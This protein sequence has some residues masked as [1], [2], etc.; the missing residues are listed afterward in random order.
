MAC[1]PAVLIEQ[2]KCI[3]ACIP[4]GMMPAVNASLLCQI[5]DMSSLPSGLIHYWSLNEAAGS[6]RVD[7]IGGVNLSENGGTID[8]VLG[9]NANAVQFT[10]NNSL[11]SAAQIEWNSDFSL[12]AWVKLDGIGDFVIADTILSN[13]HFICTNGA[14]GSIQAIGS[15][16]SA[17]LLTTSISIGVFHLLVLTCGSV[18]QALYV[19]GSIVDTNGDVG[20]HSANGPIQIRRFNFSG[21]IVDAVMVFNRVLTQQDITSLWNSGAGKFPI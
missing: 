7:S 18:T 15:D 4:P 11:I 19:D 14:T 12:A 1:D 17:T 8:S 20:G 9:K 3:N 16:N 13:P 5:L 21:A 2:A 6:A 10:N